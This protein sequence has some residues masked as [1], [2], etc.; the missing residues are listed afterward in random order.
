MFFL[1]EREG[2]P[3]KEGWSKRFKGSDCAE[4][5][6]KSLSFFPPLSLACALN[7]TRPDSGTGSDLKRSV[8][9]EKTG[10][11]A[12]QGGRGW[13]VRERSHPA[14]NGFNL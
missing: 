13:E 12:V 14:R 2:K 3:Q 4:I 1:Q 8:C 10:R 7:S 6:L 9:G 11:G 5:I